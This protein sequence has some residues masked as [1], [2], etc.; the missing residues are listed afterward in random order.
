MKQF[1]AAS[2]SLNPFDL[3]ARAPREARAASGHH[4]FSDCTLYSERCL[5]VP[6][7]MAQ[8]TSFCIGRLLQSRR[9]CADYPAGDRHW[10]GSLAMATRRRD[11][12]GQLTAAPN[13]RADFG[14]ANRPSLL[15]A[16]APAC[17]EHLAGY[18]ISRSD[19][20]RADGDYAYRP[21]RWNPQ[22]P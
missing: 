1:L 14:V 9:R 21:S 22:R 16:L 3:K 15:D 10:A 18:C 7:G 5:R 11:S 8:A 20:G 13:L 12:Q 2:H 6:G 19:V 4:S 17:E